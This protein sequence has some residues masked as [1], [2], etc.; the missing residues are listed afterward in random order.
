MLQTALGSDKMKKS[1]DSIDIAKFIGSVLVFTMHFNPLSDY[2]YVSII[3]QILARW[4]VPFFFVCSAFFLFNKSADGNIDRDTI[5]IY[6]YRIGSL[7]AVWLVYNIPNVIYSRLYSKDLSAVSTWL[8]FIKNSVL[9]STFTGSW[10]LASSIFSA[11]FVYLLSKKFKTKTIL[12]ITAVFYLLCVFTSAYF[13]VLPQGIKKVLTFLCF[14]LNI[15][16][17]CFYFAIGKYIAEDKQVVFK[18]IDKRRAMTGFIIFYS[19]FVVE[20]ALST[21]FKVLGSTDIA[22]STVL[23][24]VSLF[25]FCLQANVKINHGLLLRKLS[26]IIYCCQGNVLLVNGLVKNT[27]KVPSILAFVI[28]SIIAAGICVVVLYIQKHTHWKWSKY[29]T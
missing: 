23:M 19:I 13:G 22:F 3:P 20:T 5:N 24:S 27:F 8:V 10:Y 15:F 7:Y 29:L 17:G 9:S 16:N 6:I 26:I 1:L 25:L 18:K 14:P 2:K 4:G 11:W 21:Y 28:S 12:G